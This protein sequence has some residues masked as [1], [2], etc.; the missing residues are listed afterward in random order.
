MIQN[1]VMICRIEM[2]YDIRKYF[3]DMMNG[4]EIDFE[5]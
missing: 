3:N 1:A 2:R 5:Q 4:I